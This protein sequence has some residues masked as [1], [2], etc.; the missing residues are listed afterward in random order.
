MTDPSNRRTSPQGPWHNWPLQRIFQTITGLVLVFFT[1]VLIL[2]VRQYLLY[3]QCRQAVAA[4][5]RLLFQFTTIKD[6]LNES[7]VKG[8]EINLRN[9]SDELQATPG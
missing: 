6:H 2:G 7:L 8:Q 1:V 3:N 5:D 4:S 9:L